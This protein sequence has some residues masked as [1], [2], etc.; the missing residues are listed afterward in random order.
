[1]PSHLGIQAPDVTEMPPP[2]S[3]PEIVTQLPL[4]D[5]FGMMLIVGTVIIAGIFVFI[6]I[7]RSRKK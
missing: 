7:R 2:L 3:T 5:Q 1:M 4:L 6:V